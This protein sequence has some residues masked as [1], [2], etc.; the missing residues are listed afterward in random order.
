M[1]EIESLRTKKRKEARLWYRAFPGW[2]NYLKEL[3]EFFSLDAGVIDENWKQGIPNLVYL[4][5]QIKLGEMKASC[6]GEHINYGYSL[7][8]PDPRRWC[9]NAREFALVG[10]PKKVR[11]EYTSYWHWDRATLKLEFETELV[12]L[13]DN[14]PEMRLLMDLYSNQDISRHVSRLKKNLPFLKEMKWDPTKHS[15][16]MSEYYSFDYD[17]QIRAENSRKIW[18][19]PECYKKFKE[20]EKSRS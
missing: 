4:R 11:R 18:E 14:F 9:P 7:W 6:V 16:D 19:P 20:L 13:F 10:D 8:N 1:K 15:Y 17:A 5:I 3:I 2:S 12:P